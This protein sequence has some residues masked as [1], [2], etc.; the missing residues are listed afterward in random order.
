M[1]NL[2]YSTNRDKTGLHSFS[3]RHENKIG[4][5]EANRHLNFEPLHVLR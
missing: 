3:I 1:K 2:P 5:D 4:E